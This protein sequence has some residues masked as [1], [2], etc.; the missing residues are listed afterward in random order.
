MKPKTRRRDSIRPIA[1]IC[2]GLL[3]LLATVSAPLSHARDETPSAL[4]RCDS[5]H[6][7]GGRR[8]EPSMPLIYGQP[9]VYILTMLEEFRSGVRPSTDMFDEVS[10]YSDEELDEL[11]H[12]VAERQP[13]EFLQETD[14][15]LAAIGKPI[16]AKRC[17][18]C[19]PD[20][21]RGS[22]HGAAILAGQPL[23]YLSRQ[24]AAI[25]K[26]ERPV[27]YLM[28]DRYVGLTQK[29]FEALAHFFASRARTRPDADDGE[30]R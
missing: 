27:L 11:S 20:E 30:P 25:K 6:T 13:V 28:R 22:E 26:R 1:A 7:P 10:G 5:C 14:P 17:S 16:Y 18:S 23:L 9:Q 4:K 24:F 19:H 2:L 15:A 3:A 29:D 21:G 12:L 8:F